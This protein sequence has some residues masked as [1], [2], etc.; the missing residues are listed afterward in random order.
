MFRLQENK[1]FSVIKRT[2][3]LESTHWELSFEWSH[4]QPVFLE[5]TYLPTTCRHFLFLLLIPFYFN[6]FPK[7]TVWWSRGHCV[8]RRRQHTREWLSQSPRA[9]LQL[10]R[11]IRVRVWHLRRRRRM[12]QESMWHR[13]YQGWQYYCCGQ[14]KQPCANILKKEKDVRYPKHR[15]SWP[16]VWGMISLIIV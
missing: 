13:S 3:P 7:W 10:E 11:R 8:R 1:L 5:A 2:V 14:W 6:R 12:F 4:P 15:G 16:V 9:D